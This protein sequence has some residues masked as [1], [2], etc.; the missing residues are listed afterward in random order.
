MSMGRASRSPPRRGSAG[1]RPCEL[2]VGSLRPRAP[3]AVACLSSLRFGSPE[4]QRVAVV[5]AVVRRNQDEA[6][7]LNFLD[8]ARLVGAQVLEHPARARPRL[9]AKVDE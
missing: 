3:C 2:R 7:L 5:E 1:A 4:A 9:T 8:H 6:G